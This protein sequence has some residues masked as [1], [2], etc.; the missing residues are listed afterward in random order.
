MV[1]CLYSIEHRFREALTYWQKASARDPHNLWAWY[2]LGCCYEQLS[3]SAHAVACYTA[4]I[5]LTPDF[6][7]WYFHRGVAYLKQHDYSLASQDFDRAIQLQ[8]GRRELRVNRAL[9]R[10]GEN[11]SNDAITDLR[12]AIALGGDNARVYLILA[13]VRD[14][15]GDV[16]GAKRDR[17]AA[18]KCQPADDLAWVAQGVAFLSSDPVAAMTSFDQALK[19]NSHCLPALESKAHVLAEKLGRTEEAVAA[20]DRAVAIYPEQASTRAS[21][22][23]LLARLG[24]YETA[25]ADAEQALSLDSSDAVEYQ[26]S[27]IYALSSQE[28]PADRKRAIA[29]LTSALRHG[30]GTELIAG[31]ADL[32]VLRNDPNF[33]KVLLAAQTLQTR[34]L[35]EL[36]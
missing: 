1:A 31:D 6:G 21:R 34:A 4:C 2:G 5:A 7:D 9:A 26:V 20:L 35:E 19:C 23:V 15:I 10:L 11:R 28:S 27:G 29:L 18:L 33:Q 32:N 8:P 17:Q 12:E 30:Y 24:N 13:Q 16:V 3:Q 25:R 14:K 36:K 22:G